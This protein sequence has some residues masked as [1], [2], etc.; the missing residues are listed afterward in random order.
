M[1]SSLDAWVAKMVTF[2]RAV[3]GI[4]AVM[5]TAALTYLAVQQF[6]GEPLRAQELWFLGLIVAVT[7]EAIV[8]FF[9]PQSVGVKL[10]IWSLTLMG[11]S[12]MFG[13]FVMSR[14]SVVALGLLMI[15]AGYV[16]SIFPTAS[17]AADQQARASDN[18]AR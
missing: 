12:C 13:G 18:A 1:A 3:S 14:G 16:M 7:F 10:T 15:M 8:T 5:G 6:S 4:M 2:R 9:R 11:C 17:L